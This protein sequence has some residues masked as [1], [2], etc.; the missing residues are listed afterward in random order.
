MIVNSIQWTYFHSNETKICIHDRIFAAMS[1]K[2]C[3]STFDKADLP[4]DVVIPMM[5]HLVWSTVHSGLSSFHLGVSSVHSGV[6][7]VYLGVSSVHLKIYILCSLLDLSSV[8]SQVCSL[9]TQMVCSM[10]TQIFLRS[11]IKVKWQIHECLLCTQACPLSTR[12][13]PMS[14]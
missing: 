11:L 12:V 3:S 7:S 6:S 1:N 4:W 14:H 10:S 13:C 8:Y 5:V 9:S 2:S